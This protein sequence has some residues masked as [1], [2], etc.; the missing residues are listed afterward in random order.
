ML[1]VMLDRTG[2]KVPSGSEADSMVRPCCENP[3]PCCRYGR[4]IS[5]L[6]T[7]I[8]HFEPYELSIPNVRYDDITGGRTKTNEPGAVNGY[9]VLTEPLPVAV[10]MNR[11]FT[12]ILPVGVP[13]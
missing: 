1:F 11:E 10:T 4:L 2:F 7:V 9:T 3:L 13:Q 6:L 8:Q 12:T 5:P